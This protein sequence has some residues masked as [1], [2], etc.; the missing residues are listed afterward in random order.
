[1]LIK[2]IKAEILAILGQAAKEVEA[3]DDDKEPICGSAQI[4]FGSQS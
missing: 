4:D 2:E 3:V 1:M